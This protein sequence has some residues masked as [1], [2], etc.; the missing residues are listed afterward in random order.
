MLMTPGGLAA[1]FALAGLALVVLLPAVALGAEPRDPAWGPPGRVPL[2]EVGKGLDREVYG[3][4]HPAAGE[5]MLQVTDYSLLSTVAYFGIPAGRNGRLRTHLSS[6]AVNRSW[7]FWK[8]ATMDR[9]IDRAHAAGTEVVLTVTRFGW[10]SEGLESTVR[11]L[12]S[13]TRCERLAE[14]IADKIRRRGVD[15][16]NIDFEPIPGS[17]KQNFVRFIRTLRVALDDVRP[18]LDLSV[19]ATGYVANYDVA[20]LT[21]PGGADSIF[22]MAYHYNGSWSR[23]AGSVAPLTRSSY[24]VTDTVDAY[25][26]LAPPGKIILGV[27]YYGYMWSTASKKAGARTQPIGSTYGYPR[28]SIYS[29][30]VALAQEHGRRWDPVEQGPWVRSQYRYCSSCPLTW[31]QLY[32]ED[33]Q[34]LG[35]KYDLINDRDLRGVGIWALGYE[36]SRTELNAVLREKFVGP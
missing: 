18:G 32:Y 25:T 20:G 7:S 36:R 1:R 11:L 31:R 2:A 16:V 33:E 12:S 9:I 13:A 10:T 22:V 14:E 19:A 30:A 17:H 24:D 35:L 28:S 26:E 27:P 3:F 4:F 5:H 34:S 6:G 21:A 15:G 29:S 8:G 23:R